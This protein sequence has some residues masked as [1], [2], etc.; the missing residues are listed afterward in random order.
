V[1][2]VTAL[3]WAVAALI[4][5]TEW[6]AVTFG[7]I[8]A[9]LSGLDIPIPAVP[10]LLTPFSSTLVHSGLLHLLFN[11]F[12]LMLC[13]LAIERVLGKA[14]LLVLYLVGA[15]AAAFAQWLVAPHSPVPVIGA[16][17]AVSAI[18][19]AYAVSFSQQKQLVAS[20]RLNRWINAAWLLA[21]WTVM[22]MLVGFAAG[23]QGV[24]LATPAHVGGFLVGLLLQRPLLLWRYR[25]A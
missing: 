24:L 16:S 22:Q 10:A 15:V 21:A 11:L 23:L 25:G 2:A 13:G 8:P 18:I 6:A 12:M 17:G 20:P 1:A 7:F 5:A 14:G 3:A 9:R 4:G 19:G